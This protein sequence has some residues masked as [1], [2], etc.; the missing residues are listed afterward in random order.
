MDLCP[1]GDPF[2]EVSPTFSRPR[3]VPASGRTGLVVPLDLVRKVLGGESVVGEGFVAAPDDL[4]V[5]QRHGLL[6]QPGGFEGFLGIEVHPTLDQLSVP[7]LPDHSALPAH[8]DAASS[9]PPADALDVDHD[10]PAR[11][12]EPIILDV[13]SLHY[14]LHV[15]QVL[16]H[17]LGPPI[18]PLIRARVELESGSISLIARC[19]SRALKASVNRRTRFTFWCDIAYSGSPAASRAF[20]N[21]W[22]AT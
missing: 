6:P 18:D 13:Q 14:R 22:V 1:S 15:P 9:P 17:P 7:Q 2:R 12:E 8:G 11:V 16:D 4:H 20:S 19:V 5:L 10:V 21:S 3:W